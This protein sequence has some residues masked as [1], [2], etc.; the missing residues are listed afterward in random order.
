MIC[1]NNMVQIGPSLF[2]CFNVV[3]STCKW[4]NMITRKKHK[5]NP[6]QQDDSLMRNEGNKITL[7]IRESQKVKHAYCCSLWLPLVVLLG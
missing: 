5:N 7:S 4:C 1:C 6:T 2:L 3:T